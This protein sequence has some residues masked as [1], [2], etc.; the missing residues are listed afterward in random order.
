M[1]SGFTAIIGRPNVGKSTMLNAILGEKVAITADKPQTTRNRIRGIYNEDGECQIVFLDTPGITRPKNKLGEYMRAAALDSLADVDA[2]LF[3]TDQALPE[4][5]GDNY[6]I[7]RLR[8]ADAPIILA[9]NK[10]DRI[11]PDEYKQAYESFESLGMFADIL[12]TEAVSGKNVPEL[13]T[14]LKKHMPE[15]PQ[16]FPAGI[17]TDL[18]ERFLVSEMIREKMLHYLRDEVPHGV[19]VEIEKFA[20]KDNITHI[21]AVIYTEKKS[22][23]G[24]IIGK[25]GRKLKGIGKSAREDVEKLLA[26]KV[27]LELWVKVKDN[28]RDSD[29]MLGSLG[30]KDQ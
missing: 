19:A 10:I 25:D 27:F 8:K 5:G 16:F 22:H 17:T 1:K 29:F 18:S 28:W 21:S 15:G 14:A 23:K 30:Y 11:G 12:G 4:K 9:I 7:E 26:Q 13:V 3:V 24:I 2:A 6:I 20:E